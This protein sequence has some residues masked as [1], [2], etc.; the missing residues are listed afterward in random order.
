MIFK[1]LTTT[2][3]WGFVGCTMTDMSMVVTRSVGSKT[4]AFMSCC[5]L[6][7]V[8]SGSGWM[9]EESVV[10]L[11]RLNVTLLAN[12]IVG[13]QKLLIPEMRCMVLP[14]RVVLSSA[15]DKRHQHTNALVVV[16]TSLT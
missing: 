13:I 6:V 14:E 5:H 1:A 3:W 11:F 12:G 4:A 2:G 10:V 9:I 16:S 7:G 8:L 15:T